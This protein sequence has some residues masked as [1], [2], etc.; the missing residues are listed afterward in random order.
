MIEKNEPKS[1]EHPETPFVHKE[2][3]FDHKDLKNVIKIGFSAFFMQNRV[4]ETMLK[5]SLP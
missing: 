3:A 2:L 4:S 5:S 1:A